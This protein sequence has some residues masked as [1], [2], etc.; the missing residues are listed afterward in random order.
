M[1]RRQN[2]PTLILLKNWL[3]TWNK[4]ILSPVGQS[5]CSVSCSRNHQTR[6]CDTSRR[7]APTFSIQARQAQ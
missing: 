5:H 7:K 1:R 4:R 2:S 3:D 6:R